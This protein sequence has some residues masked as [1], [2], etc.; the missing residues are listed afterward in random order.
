MQLATPF[1]SVHEAV[2]H[3]GQATQSVQLTSTLVTNMARIF[4][5]AASKSP[6]LLVGPPGAGK[7]LAV[8]QTAK[9]VGV[10]CARINCSQSI[11]VEQLFGSI[12]LVVRNGVR[13]FEWQDG[14]ITR[15]LRAGCW[16]L[17]DEVNLCPPEVLDALSPLLQHSDRRIPIPGHPAWTAPKFV[18]ASSG[19][20]L[21]T[22]NP[23]SVGGN[24]G[25]LPRS[26]A[27]LFT[28]V[29]LSE[30][31]E[32]ELLEIAQCLFQELLPHPDPSSGR[33][34]AI[35]PKQLQSVFEA[36]LE[37]AKLVNDRTV[38]VAGG[39]HELNMRDLAKLRDVLRGTSRDFADHCRLL[40]DSPSERGHHT[41]T[42]AA[43]GGD[44]QGTPAGSLARSGRTASSDLRALAL[45]RCAELVY[46]AQFPDP[47]DQAR[48]CK[49]L[50]KALPLSPELSLLASTLSADTSFPSI[51]R[52][53]TVFMQVES[54]AESTRS[55]PVPLVHTSSTLARLERLG[56]AIQSERGILLEGPAC[57]G[58]TALVTE[59]ARLAKRTL[60]VIPLHMDTEV[61][62]LIGQW[63][64]VYRAAD[65]SAALV[66]SSRLLERSM[67]DVIGLAGP[68][69]CR[70]DTPEQ[71]SAFMRV[72]QCIKTCALLQG[73][74]ALDSL[75][76]GTDLDLPADASRMQRAL[77]AAKLL[78]VQC[79]DLRRLS[80]RNALPRWV[81]SEL[82][83]A[84]RKLRRWRAQAKREVEQAARH[85]LAFRFVESPLVN[86]VRNGHWVLLDNVNCAPPDVVERLNSLLEEDP[87]LGLHEHAD[88]EELTRANE[89][90]HPRFRIIA[91][92]NGQRPEAHKLSGAF[93][94]RMLRIWLAPLDAGLAEVDGSEAGAKALDAHD[95][96]AITAFAFADVVG[97][98]QVARLL[99]L[100]HGKAKKCF[101]SSPLL[102]GHGFPITFRNLLNAAKFARHLVEQ[103]RSPTA[104]AA[105]GFI[106]NY[107][108]GV[109][110]QEGR[111]RLLS[112]LVCVLKCPAVVSATSSVSAG[113]SQ[114]AAGPQA[115]VQGLQ[116]AMREV[117]AA[118]AASV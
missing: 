68:W 17:L 82:V 4:A 114:G 104:A 101:E 11:T 37:I 9:L 39:R 50:D 5:A 84:E 112:E 64:P 115:M 85:E 6:L 10:A 65:D 69:L 46:S 38:G 14:S 24:R 18:S 77:A 88:G 48:I 34:V 25:R 22:M 8:L 19:R 43:S 73:T 29:Q 116:L 90:V 98:Q 94:N 66:E 56:A 102:A 7:T 87:V 47:D 2:S 35:T 26:I 75:S 59:L 30:C 96:T 12:M 49:A 70:S 106:R 80:G 54:E 32:D 92:A 21:G 62:D 40:V 28:R 20:V 93:L 13:V 109:E 41:S 16:V 118:C 71:N 3:F 15:A 55:A 78:L 100:A 61:S 53:G 63:Q 97:G 1:P 60:V 72:I 111:A 76:L 110:P 33:Y 57:S 83:A 107:V 99:A 79:M 42:Q 58:K 95:A 91:C 52:V 113:A 67:L 31:S 108:A 36:H 23:A 89:G 103:G 117:E 74:A 27:N 44:P 105:A 45:R 81:A 51:L 86:A